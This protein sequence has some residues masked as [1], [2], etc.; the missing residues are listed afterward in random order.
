MQRE[1]EA[2]KKEAVSIVSTLVQWSV[3]L[4]RRPRGMA[5]PVPI[6]AAVLRPVKEAVEPRPSLSP[7]RKPLPLLMPYL[8]RPRLLFSLGAPRTEARARE[9]T[10]RST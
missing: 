5:T 1:V 2:A 10:T 3:H 4:P 8:M 9:V 6:L 7:A